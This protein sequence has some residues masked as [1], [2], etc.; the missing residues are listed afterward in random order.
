MRVL[1]INPASPYSFWSFEEICRLSGR[2]SLIP[3]L[4]LLTAAALLPRSWELRL[5]DLSARP[6]AEEDW[7]FAEA[8]FLTGML[9]QKQSLLELV[10][11]AKRRGKTVVVG[12]PYVTSLPEDVR[13][14]GADIIV[15]GEGED[16]I[17]TLA[18]DLE[19]GKA[20]PLY[21]AEGRPAM[22][23]SPVPRFDLLRMDD[24]A[25]MSVQ[26]SRGCP[27]D[28]EFCD[29]VNLY[30]KKP[31]FKNPEQVVAELDELYRLGWRNEVFFCDDNFIGNKR[32]ARELLN[33]L[34]PWMQ[35]R[36]E[37]FGYW[38]Q[39]SV[40]LGQDPELID[41]MTAANFSTVFIGV[42]SPD[43]AILERSHKLQ[44]IK[45][46]LA[47]SLRAINENGLSIIASFIMGFD[48]E[49]PGA[50]D[51]IVD[52]VEQVGLPQAMINLMQILPNTRLWTRMQKEGR[53][54]KD[55][56]TGD[57]V[58]LPLNYEPSRDTA[59]LLREYQEAWCRLYAPDAFIGRLEKYY[60]RMRPTR[61]AMAAKAGQPERAT[62]GAVSAQVQSPASPGRVRGISSYSGF[63]RRNP[64]RHLYF[65]V[66]A[67]LKLT[68]EFGVRSRARKVYWKSMGRIWR[69]NGSRFVAYFH[70]LALGYNTTCYVRALDRRLEEHFKDME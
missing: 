5:A 37:P 28:C 62:L 41:Q 8:V 67:F 61:S 20:R 12:G 32:H 4:G 69:A 66:L 46:P 65:D 24:Y 25:T 70:G 17:Q 50:G 42:E 15:Q 7:E 47:D 52:F 64:L 11:E 45:N 68:L 48:G 14:A 16:V 39:A 2:K 13:D 23:A 55:V 26:T 51:R 38:T 31:R 27:H 1:L 58:G 34:I 33:A 54:H 63:R 30:G 35:K 21:K 9:L 19:Q 3:P 53:L 60:T 40:D 18:V 22:E 43:E 57:T 56:T 10:V 44:N 49:E 36:G 59:E 6:V 29:I